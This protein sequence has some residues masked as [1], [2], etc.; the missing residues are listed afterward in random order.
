MMDLLGPL[1][2]SFRIALAAGA[3]ALAAT[4]PA[5]AA[6]KSFKVLRSFCT[7]PSCI[8]GASPSGTLLMDEAH[9]LYG[10]TESGGAHGSGIVYE[11][12]NDDTTG[13]RL[14]ILYNFCNLVNCTDGGNPVRNKLVMDVDGQIYGTTQNGG[15]TGNGT[16][17]VM[18]PNAAHT[19]Y[20]QKVIHNFCQDFS[21]CEDGAAPVG[22]LTYKGA[23]SGAAYDGVSPLFGITQLGGH[24][25]VGVV[26]EM[27]PNAD[28]S[29]WLHRVLY[30]FCTVGHDCTDGKTPNE[31]LYVDSH[32]NVVGTTSQGG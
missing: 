27:I 20:T 18:V 25:H 16:V 5:S 32:S 14:K 17:F 3:L 8:D 6:D 23:S 9:N 19:H 12:V 31:S 2:T 28:Q 15:S 30:V 21:G 13:Y 24:K 26:Y 22:G 10:T 11:M 4:A 29:H 7:Q 1:K